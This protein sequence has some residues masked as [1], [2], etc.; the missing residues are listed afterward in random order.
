MLEAKAKDQGHRR[1]CSPKKKI[2]FRRSQK[3]IR[4][5]K[6]ILLV[7]ELLRRDFYVQAYADDLALLVTGADML[8]IRGID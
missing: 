1:K 6:N 4:S 7:L 2:F 5:S 3:T 8:W